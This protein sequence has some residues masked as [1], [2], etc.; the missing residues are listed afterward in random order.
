MSDDNIINMKAGSCLFAIATLFLISCASKQI[1]NDK[2]ECQFSPDGVCIK[3]YV[4]VDPKSVERAQHIIDQMLKNSPEIKKKM[5]ENNFIVE[6]IGRNQNTTDLPRYRYLKKEKTFDG[7][8]YDEGTRGLG[9]AQGCNVGEEN[10]LCLN[11]QNFWNEN[12]LVHECAHTI[13]YHITT[14]L[15]QKIEQA[16]LQAKKK[17][18]Y[19]ESIYMMA[20]SHEYWALATQAWFNAIHRRDV[21]DGI[22]TRTAIMKHDPEISKILQKVYGTTEIKKLNHCAY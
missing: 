16:Y 19:S 10:L 6:I 17:K 20:N 21:N 9:D 15:S 2:A 5:I 12:I 13:H 3:A 7:R 4:P 1:S 18:L 22:T 8:S 14:D 11:P